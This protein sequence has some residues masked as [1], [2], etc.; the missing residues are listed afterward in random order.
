MNNTITKIK[1]T[2]E[3]TNSRITETEECISEQ[4][5]RVVE[6]NAKEQ[7]KKNN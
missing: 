4:E 1:N 2:L 6:I 3:V 7:E 5:D